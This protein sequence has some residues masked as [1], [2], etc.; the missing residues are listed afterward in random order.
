M[1]FS[2]EQME[3]MIR[4]YQEEA[5]RYQQK[6]TNDLYREEIPAKEVAVQ[7]EQPAVETAAVSPEAVRPSAEEGTP[8]GSAAPLGAYMED[9]L[10][11]VGDILYSPE[12]LPLDEVVKDSHFKPGSVPYDD[13]GRLI[14]EV[15]AGEQSLPVAFANVVVVREVEGEQELIHYL[16]TDIS[17]STPVIEL[18]A[19]AR[20]L[21][22]QPEP[23]GLIPYGVYTVAVSQ[24]D[25]YTTIVKDVQIFAGQTAIL[26]VSMIPLSEK[27]V[28][29]SAPNRNIE[30]DHHSLTE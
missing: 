29:P 26:P 30:T 7:A 2:Q 21:S 4:K 24:T 3:A 27:S 17:G 9:G 25:Y 8:T 15:T 1:E 14:V 19:P 16:Q 23:A 10:S 11:G 6:S 22:E 12:P 18:P 5:L 28:N 13:S 20:G